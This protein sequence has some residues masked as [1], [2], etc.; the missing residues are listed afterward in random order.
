MADLFRKKEDG[1]VRTRKF[2]TKWTAKE[3][4]Q[5]QENSRIRKLSMNEFIIRAAL[6]RRADIKMDME[7]VS[8][9]S[10]SISAVRKLHNFCE[11]NN[12]PMAEGD[13]ELMRISITEG[14]EAMRR[15]LK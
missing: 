13:I 9:L 15:I 2:L 14:I 4:S 1:D 11:V 12:L 6:G 8:K 5:A 10:Q 3:F 7:I